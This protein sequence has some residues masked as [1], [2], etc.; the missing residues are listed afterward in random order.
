[1]SVSPRE[2]ALFARPSTWSCAGVV[3]EKTASALL[4]IEALIDES[5]M[6]LLFLLSEN[7]PLYLS[8]PLL[9]H[10]YIYP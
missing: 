9:I 10:I 7:I 3:A 2:R 1:M 8:P 6:V 4:A 5:D